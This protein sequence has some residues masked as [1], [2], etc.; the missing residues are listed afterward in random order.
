MRILSLSL[1]RLELAHFQLRKPLIVIGRAP[2]CDVVLRA[3]GI[4][5]IHFIVEWIGNGKFDP[6]VTSGMWSIVDVSTNAEAGEGLVLGDQAI[7]VDDISFLLVESKLESSEVIGGRIVDSLTAGNTDAPDLLEF[8]QVRN[9]SGA[10]EEVRH[11][12]VP[13]KKKSE[14]LSKEFKEFKIERNAMP[15]DALLNVMLQELPG[16]EVFLAGRKVDPKNY[17]GLGANDFLQVKWNGRNFYLRF[18]E[19]VKS[20]PIP[21]DFWGDPL[22]KWLTVGAAALFLLFF[23]FRGDPSKTLPEVTPPV[24]VARIEVAPPPPPPIKEPEVKPQ[25]EETKTEKPEAVIEKKKVETTPAKSG[26]AKVVSAPTAK[27]KAGLNIKAPVTN[28]NRIGILGALNK[29]VSKGAGI[30]A[31][32]VINNGIVTEAA[33]GSNDAKIVITNPP[34]GVIGTGNRGGAPSGKNNPSLGSAS[35]TLAGVKNAAPDSKSLI[36]KSG[37][38]GNS[39]LGANSNGIGAVSEGTGSSAKIGE[40][41]GD[42]AVSGGLDRDTVRRIIQSYR[43]QVRACYDRALVSSPNLQGRISYSW[44][45]L[46]DGGVVDAKVAKTTVESPNLKACVLEVI[47]QMQFPKSSRGMSTTVI[48]PFVFQGMK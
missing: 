21:R 18:V 30:R 14:S 34:A 40:G 29:N 38:V 41:A 6:S 2:T 4:K 25:I 1:N 8:V 46:S 39:G 43:A 11:V 26:A 23:L 16:A 13:K 48:Y 33:T 10:I 15:T 3:P 19:E 22:L 27:P 17:V 20:P 36:A 32:Q 42:F 24:R 35:T 9:D 12:L 44:K 45:I 7:V 37:G 5:P 47:Q 31:D 28:V